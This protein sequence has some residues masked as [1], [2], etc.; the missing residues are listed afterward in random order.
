MHVQ[1]LKAVV[2]GLFTGCACHIMA[3]SVGI[4]RGNS[5]LESVLLCALMALESVQVCARHFSDERDI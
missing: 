1:L 5:M 2:K 4:H 3:R